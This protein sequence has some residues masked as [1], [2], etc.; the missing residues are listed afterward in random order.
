M[1]FVYYFLISCKSST[2][3]VHTDTALSGTLGLMQFLVQSRVPDEFSGSRTM[4]H[5]HPIILRDHK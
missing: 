2:K 3:I 4:I 1:N 5:S